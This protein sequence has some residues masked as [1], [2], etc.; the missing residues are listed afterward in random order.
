MKTVNIAYCIFLFLRY[1]K[2]NK[3]CSQMN[4]LYVTYEKQRNFVFSAKQTFVF[5]KVVS[6]LL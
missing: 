5:A 4:C 2:N 3:N 6:N 1:L